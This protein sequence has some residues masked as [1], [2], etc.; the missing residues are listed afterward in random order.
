MIADNRH[1]AHFDLDAFFVPVAQ[2]ENSK[3]VCKS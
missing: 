1:I 3:L 2:K